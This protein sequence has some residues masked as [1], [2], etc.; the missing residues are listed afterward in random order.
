MGK[1]MAPF[2]VSVADI[3]TVPEDGFGDSE[4]AD[5]LE[6]MGHLERGQPHTL[7]TCISNMVGE[8]L[9]MCQSVVDKSSRIIS[10]V[11]TND[12]KEDTC[13]VD[14]IET[15]RSF[16]HTVHTDYN[17]VRN[18]V[19][20]GAADGWY[21]ASSLG[22]SPPSCLGVVMCIGPVMPVSVPIVVCG[23]TANHVV[24]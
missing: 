5:Y 19:T 23:A 4:F 14:Y 7:T 16:I 20:G 17:E 8:A 9:S 15:A 24:A 12:A 2:P 13:V 1:S 18:I 10:S 6:V 21:P 22:Q 3:S 11:F